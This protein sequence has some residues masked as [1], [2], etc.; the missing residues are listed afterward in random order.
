MLISPQALFF[1]DLLYGTALAP[2]HARWDTRKYR[3]LPTIQP[4][5]SKQKFKVPDAWDKCFDAL[6]KSHDKFGKAI[7]SGT[8]FDAEFKSMCEDAQPAKRPLK[9]GMVSAKRWTSTLPGDA[10]PSKLNAPGELCLAEPGMTESICEDS[11]LEDFKGHI[12]PNCAFT[13]SAHQ[14]PALSDSTSLSSPSSSSDLST[15]SLSEASDNHYNESDCIDGTDKRS[16]PDHTPI[17]ASWGAVDVEAIFGDG[18]DELEKIIKEEE[19]G[20]AWR[21]CPYVDLN[22]LKA[23]FRHT[24]G[25]LDQSAGLHISSSPSTEVDDDV[26]ASVRPDKHVSEEEQQHRLAAW[27]YNTLPNGFR[28]GYDCEERLRHGILSENAFYHLDHKKLRECK[29]VPLPYGATGQIQPLAPYPRG[30]MGLKYWDDGDVPAKYWVPH[31]M[32]E[33]SFQLRKRFLNG[34]R[35]YAP[36][37]T[38]LREVR[39]VFYRT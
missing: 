3:N 10:T 9:C 22:G 24:L 2:Y 6:D 19:K 31:G 20:A 34:H 32:G 12:A 26:V 4:Y 17:P 13:G 11:S 21:K 33:D 14:T 27:A 30:S 37:P 28:Y 18:D 8:K 7:Q 35:F 36:Q 15:S 25:G 1:I 16:C 23:P 5:H 38:C 29:E 39:T